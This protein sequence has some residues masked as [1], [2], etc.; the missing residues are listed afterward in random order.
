MFTATSGKHRLCDGIT[1]RAFIQIGALGGLTLAD[2]LRLKAQQPAAQ[3]SPKAVILIFL[4]GGAS[5]LDTYDL[6]PEAPAEYRGEFKPIRTSVPGFQ[7]CELMPRQAQ[8]A[9][10][11]SVLCGVQAAVDDHVYNEVF[12]GFPKGTARPA[13]GSL[14]SRFS[15]RAG[16]GLPSY[17]SLGH[18]LPEPRECER[19]LYAG[20]AHG[21]FRP[22][23]EGLAD[24]ARSKLVTLP[25]LED[26]K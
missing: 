16:S 10:H 20:A 15:P 18:P 8:I 2:V 25:R 22:R 13:W 12:T 24:L 14:V 7:V 5:H 17:V 21:P 1:R 26:R 3:A 11:L 4:E 19:P 9:R 23:E 6:K